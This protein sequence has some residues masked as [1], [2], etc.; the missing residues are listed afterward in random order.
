MRPVRRPGRN[1]LL[2][3]IGS[4]IDSS[5]RGWPPVH[6]G[7]SRSEVLVVLAAVALVVVPVAVAE[8]P[9]EMARWYQAAAMERNLDGDYESAVASMDRAIAWHDTDPLLYLQRAQYK[10][11]AEQWESGLEDCDRARQLVPDS[12]SIGALRSQFLQHLGRHREA[13]AELGEI[14]HASG[15]TLPSDRAGQLE[16]ADQLNRMA[17][18]MAVGDINLEQGL[19]AVE[20]SLQLVNDVTAMLDPAG[21]LCFGRAATARKIGDNQLALTSLTEAREY[22]ETALSRVAPPH[23]T[24]AAE[25]APDAQR[26]EDAAENLPGT[27]APAEHVQTLRAH[28]AGIL[29]LRARVC[30]ELDKPDDAA[31]DRDHIKELEVDGNLAI[32]APYDLPVAI[33]R[34][35][36]CAAVLDTR[37]FLYYKL[38]EF[39]AA[40][41]DLERAVSGMRWVDQAMSWLLDIEKDYAADVR[42]SLQEQR[43]HRQSLAVI[44]YHRALT[45]QVLGK[46]QQADQDLQTVRELGYEPGE[47]LF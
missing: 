38:Q 17:Y 44:T 22:A 33:G 27:Q 2:I 3:T 31:R 21:V 24:T 16:R 15:D 40:H 7:R 12:P 45:L 4:S 9:R 28:L 32:V 5:V 26:P 29:Q 36:N 1:N 20:A 18:T 11:S 42:Q 47:H 46:K 25:D 39:A 19:L 6:V 30:E 37:G 13:V 14:L 8:W 34:V 41:E 35:S 10:L 23:Q 43:M